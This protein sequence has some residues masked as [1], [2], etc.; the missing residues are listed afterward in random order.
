M[1]KILLVLAFLL[2]AAPGWAQTYTC[3]PLCFYPNLG[4][5]TTGGTLTGPLAV[6]AG[7]AALPTI[8]NP[9]ASQSGLYFGVGNIFWSHYGTAAGY[10][11]Y[12]TLGIYGLVGSIV[13][14]NDTKIQRDNAANTWAQVN[15]DASQY[16]RTYGGHSSYYEVGSLQEEITLSTVGTT[17]DSAADLLPANAV[18]EQVSWRVTQTVTG[19]GVTSLSLGDGTT[20]GRF[21]TL[22][23][24][25]NGNAGVGQ[26][27]LS[28]ASVTL[29]TGPSQAAAAKLR[30]TAVG[31]TPSAGKIRVI[32]YYRLA[33]IPA[34]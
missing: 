8:Y 6:P 26:I 21:A 20:A 17:T 14:N 1:K 33:T 30:V 27:H 28:G 4:L 29:A 32:V 23:T 13:I 15:A 11:G 34:T 22:V 19:A 9:S 3:P 16:W 10:L 31:G 7:T 24:L 12:G 2:A 5:P 25:T 18:I